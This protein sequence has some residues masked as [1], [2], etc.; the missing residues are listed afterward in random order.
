MLMHPPLARLPGRLIGWVVRGMA[1]RCREKA[2]QFRGSIT[3]QLSDLTG[4]LF[5]RLD[6]WFS[7]LPVEPGNQLP[8]RSLSHFSLAFLLCGRF[9]SGVEPPATVAQPAPT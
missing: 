8:D 6:S 4:D 2:S 1:L 3:D 7:F 5:E 9:A